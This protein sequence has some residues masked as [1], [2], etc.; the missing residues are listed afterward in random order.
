MADYDLAEAFKAIEDELIASM[1]RNL[2]HHQAEE[3]EQGLNWT[4]WQV[5][6]LK[7]LEKY[8]KNNQDKFSKQ[9]ENINGRITQLIRD[10]Y[11][12]GE[13][14]QERKILQA[15]KRGYKINGTN[16]PAFTGKTHTTGEF[17]GLNDRKLEALITAT[18]HDMQRAETAVLRLANDQ[19]RK[20]IFN[21]QVYANAGG[22]TYKKAVD[23]ATKDMLN[24]GL[25]CVEYKNGAKHTLSNYA[26]MAIRTATTRA[27]LQGEGTKRNEWGISTVILNKRSCPCAKC[28]PFVGKVF[29]DDVWSG[30]TAEEAKEKGYPLLSTAIEKGLYHPNCK[31]TH[32][33][34]FEGI[35]TPPEKP[36]A[37]EKQKAV[38][39]YNQ[40]QKARYN[41]LQ[42]EKCERI[43][44]Y[45]LDEENKRVYK[46]RA[47]Q[48]K[49]KEKSL[50]LVEVADDI[51]PMSNSY[52]PIFSYSKPISFNKGKESVSIP[53]KKVSNSKF[54]MVT[55]I[56]VSRRNKAVRLTEK[57]LTEIKDELPTDFELPQIAVIDFDKHGFGMDAIGGYD[58][59]TGILYLNS[60]YNTREKIK[61][62]VTAQMGQFANNTE[63]AP[64]LH[65]LGHKYYYDCIKVLAKTHNIEYNEAKK[66]IDSRIYDYIH[67]RNIDGRLLVNNISIYAASGYKD[68]NFT[69]VVAECFTVKN[70]EVAS[71]ILDLTEK[72]DKIMM[73]H[74][75]DEEIELYNKLKTCTDEEEIRIINEKLDEFSKKRQEMLKDL[76]F[77]H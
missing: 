1:I 41:A 10:Y 28:L 19:Y 68:N 66:I 26:D 21:A 16:K 14:E 61:T 62:Y 35:S 34:Y 43:S 11:S 37:E 56:D 72:G 24:A 23:M 7:A 4:Q 59:N 69:E 6:Q 36:T 73:I 12:D 46:L 39:E 49:E 2:A 44:K 15:I 29:V 40:E 25:N 9:F 17:F 38:D 22:T 71:D 64:L 63:Y 50:K 27:Y 32:T 75:S 47:E 70:K 8:R 74:M 54:N 53:V 76:P 60:K 77:A 20:A 13:T 55:D 42:A 52:R 57:L 30:G 48:W 67:E 31:D 18:T 58:K 65:E 5:E 51:D 45:S 3:T 33:T